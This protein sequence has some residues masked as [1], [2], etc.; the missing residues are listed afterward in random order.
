MRSDLSVRAVHLGA[1]RVDVHIREHVLPMNYP[2]APGNQPTPLELLLGS[3]AGCAANTLSLVLCKKMG[4]T[5]HSLEVVAT[6]ERRT[7]HP[8][9]LSEIELVYQIGGEGLDPELA[10]RAVRFAED[11]LCPVLAMLRP[12]TKIHSSWRIG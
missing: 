11:Q 3:L 7:E 6:A 2:A 9:M 5:V 12:G 1:M 10:G 8:T 4:A